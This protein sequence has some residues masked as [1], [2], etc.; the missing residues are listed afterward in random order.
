MFTT[1]NPPFGGENP[2]VY[3]TQ[4]QVDAANEFIRNF[5]KRRQNTLTNP[6][7]AYVAKKPGDPVLPIIVPPTVQKGAKK[8]FKVPST[9]RMEDI[10]GD[11]ETGYYYENNNGDIVEIDPS[12]LNLPRFRKPQVLASLGGQTY[13]NIN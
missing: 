6:E 10:K 7:D 4:Q 9:V 8:A 12:V 13:Q 2:P 5:Q 1:L 11:S 3:K